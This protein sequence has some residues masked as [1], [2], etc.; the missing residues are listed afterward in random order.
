LKHT[1]ARQYTQ[2]QN[3]IAEEKFLKGSSQAL[4][5]D[6]IGNLENH[7]FHAESKNGNESHCQIIRDNDICLPIWVPNA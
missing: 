1:Q 7:T 4:Q 6:E 5:K 2:T 3:Q